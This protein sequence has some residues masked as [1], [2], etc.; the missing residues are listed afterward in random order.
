ME[1]EIK[2]CHCAICG[3]YIAGPDQVGA[4]I[5]REGKGVAY[6]KEHAPEEPGE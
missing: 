4:V 6:C 1:N 5:F 2:S 3:K